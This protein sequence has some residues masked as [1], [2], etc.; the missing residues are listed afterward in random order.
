MNLFNLAEAEIRRE[1]RKPTKRLIL[2]YAIKI[3]R[4]FDI[5]KGVGN[6]ILAGE[7]FLQYDNRFIFK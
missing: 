5:H 3:R 6:R 2:K 1:G 7:M 4:W